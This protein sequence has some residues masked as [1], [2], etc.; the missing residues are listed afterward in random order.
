MWNMYRKP[1]SARVKVE[2]HL[3]SKVAQHVNSI[4]IGLA[5]NKGEHLRAT[6]QTVLRP[7]L[8]C[9]SFTE[10]KRPHPSQLR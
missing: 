8:L 2:S 10:Q 9:A 6:R 4:E 5:N 7:R 3:S 1:I